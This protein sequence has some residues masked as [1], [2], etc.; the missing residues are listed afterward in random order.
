VHLS[1]VS[2][3]VNAEA[4][5]ILYHRFVG[6]ML[7]MTHLKFLRSVALRNRAALVVSYS[8]NPATFEE[9]STDELEHLLPLR[10]K[11]FINLKA[12][13]IR[14]MG[15][16]G[17][18]LSQDYP[19]QLESFAWCLKSYASSNAGHVVQFLC[20]QSRLKHI[21]YADGPLL[22]SLPK[23]PLLECVIGSWVSIPAFLSAGNVKAIVWI[24]PPVWI[25]EPIPTEAEAKELAPALQRISILDLHA[26]RGV[27]IGLQIQRMSP[28]LPYL[29]TVESLQLGLASSLVSIFQLRFVRRKF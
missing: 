8:C 21:L 12:L 2:K 15:L 25:H 18:F 11:M 4:E 5:R 17:D 26:H 20:R 6:F 14:W 7:V 1:S 28:L 27:P 29:S 23:L 10:L 16:S 13:E 19:F 9:Q 24:P 22:E 3:T